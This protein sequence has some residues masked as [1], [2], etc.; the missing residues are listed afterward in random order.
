MRIISGKFKG[1]RIKISKGLPIRPTTDIAKESLFNIISNRINLN[2]LKVLDLFSGSGMMGL[3]FISRGSRVIFVDN[4][5]KC[6][7]HISNTLNI[8]EIETKLVKKDVFNYLDNC[9]KDFDLIFA[10]PP[11]NFSDEDYKKLIK[12]INKNILTNPNILFILEHFKKRDF[13]QI[14]EFFDKRC[15]GDCCF[16]FFQQKS[17]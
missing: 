12:L 17:G 15:Y 14:E 16:S 9:D 3:E 7:K 5:L 6:I 4:N 8:L 11:Y 1:R 13:S 10:D 2:G